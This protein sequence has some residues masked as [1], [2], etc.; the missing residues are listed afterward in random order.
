[1]GVNMKNTKWIWRVLAVLLALVV[2]A[3]EGGDRNSAG[4]QVA[5]THISYSHENF[6]HLF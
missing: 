5:R 2:L 3:G 1:M 4:Q 6:C